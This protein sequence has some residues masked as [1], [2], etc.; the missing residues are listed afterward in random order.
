[1]VTTFF[2]HQLS[3]CHRRYIFQFSTSIKLFGQNILFFPFFNLI[4]KVDLG[5]MWIQ[6]WKEEMNY[7]YFGKAKISDEFMP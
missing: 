3:K 2:H 5:V 7:V 6:V 4:L 1:M